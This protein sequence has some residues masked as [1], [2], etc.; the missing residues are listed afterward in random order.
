[1]AISL[2]S[3]SRTHHDTTQLQATLALYVLRQ[4]HD[5]PV[6]GLV[7]DPAAA[8]RF[9]ALPTTT[10]ATWLA[11]NLAAIRAGHLTVEDIP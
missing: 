4:A 1:M 3:D 5:T 10:R 7:A 11:T 9:A 6:P 8:D 2:F